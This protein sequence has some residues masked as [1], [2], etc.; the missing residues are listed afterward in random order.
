MSCRTQIWQNQTR[1]RCLGPDLEF[2]GVGFVP[3]GGQC[4][5]E[6]AGGAA[7]AGGEGGEGGEGQDPRPRLF[8]RPRQQP[9]RVPAGRAYC[10]GTVSRYFAPP[11]HFPI[12]ALN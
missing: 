11:P 12:V 3:A 5:G 10:K 8:L 1:L 7:G 2:G 6:P 9:T 4:G